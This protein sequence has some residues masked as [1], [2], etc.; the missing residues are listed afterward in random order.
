MTRADG[1][2][3]GK[4]VDGAVWLSGAHIAYAFYQYWINIDDR[5]VERFL[6]QLTLVPVDEV[7]AVVEAHAEAPHRREAQRR[8]AHEVTELVHGDGAAVAAAAASRLLFGGDP[9]E[10]EEASF[11][12]LEREL[13]VGEI[14]AELLDGG[15]AAVDLALSTGL[16]RLE[17][18]CQPGARRQRAGGERARLAAGDQISSADLLHSRYLLV[19]RGQ[20]PFE[21]VDYAP[22]PPPHRALALPARGAARETGVLELA[23]RGGRGR[24]SLRRQSGERTPVRFR[25]HRTMS[26][27]GRK[28]PDRLALRFKPQGSARRLA[29]QVEAPGGFWWSTSVVPEEPST[30]ALAPTRP[31]AP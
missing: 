3:F 9:A 6:L 14:T 10:A 17:E 19:R 22:R 27:T 13:E 4:S 30:R 7:R 18:R 23:G 24:F 11:R 31:G 5:D 12:M 8:L 28:H 15:L 26:L 1:A 16:V 29:L 2:K 20:K 21:L 25:A